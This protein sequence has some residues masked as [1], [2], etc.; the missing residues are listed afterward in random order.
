MKELPI[1][2]NTEMV[3]AILA[4]NKTQT[5]RL[6]AGWKVGDITFNVTKFERVQE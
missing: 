4:G 2:F 6:K 3:R 1:L 5:R